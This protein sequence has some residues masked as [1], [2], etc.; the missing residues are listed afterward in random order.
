MVRRNGSDSLNTWMKTF[1]QFVAEMDGMPGQPALP[2]NIQNQNPADLAKFSQA[3][4]MLPPN[5]K[6]ADAISGNSPKAQADLLKNT[7]RLG[8]PPFKT[9]QMIAPKLAMAGDKPKPGQPK[10]MRKK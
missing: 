3:V 5:E 2:M 8:L 1:L 4:G 10:M 7:G 9:M 6:A